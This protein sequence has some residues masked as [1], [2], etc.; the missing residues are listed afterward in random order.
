[1]SRFVF[2]PVTREL[3]Y[4]NPK[5]VE[6]PET[7]FNSN[8]GQTYVQACKSTS[9]ILIAIAITLFVLLILVTIYLIWLMYIKTND[10]TPTDIFSWF[11]RPS[12]P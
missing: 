10:Q 1:M 2:N 5:G 12:T 11:T 9:P 8:R 7:A 3:D 4:T 6:I